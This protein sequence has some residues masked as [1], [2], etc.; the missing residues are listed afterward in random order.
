[1]VA[2]S[3]VRVST[4]MAVRVRACRGVRR[5]VSVIRWLLVVSS[6][7]RMRLSILSARLAVRCWCSRSGSRTSA[8]VRGASDDRH[9]RSRE[10]RS[11]IRDDAE[12]LREGDVPEGAGF[13]ECAGESP[14]SVRL[15]GHS[16]LFRIPSI[17]KIRAK[18]R[19]GANKSYSNICK[20]CFRSTNDPSP[21]QR[22]IAASL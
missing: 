7:R 8:A 18:L 4:P 12:Y 17:E 10:T 20:Q 13:R 15:N 3:Q 2:L 9:H 22:P 5:V 11:A 21:A 6:T 16:P 19:L 1:M 14:I